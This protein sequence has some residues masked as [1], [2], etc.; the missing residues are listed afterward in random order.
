M[1][2]DF[3]KHL[4]TLSEQ[5]DIAGYVATEA[6]EYVVPEKFFIDLASHGCV[7]GMVGALI[8]Y[9]DTHVFFEYNYA[10]IQELKDEWESDCGE[11]LRIEDD[12]KNFL[13]WFAFEVKAYRMVNEWEGR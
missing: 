3:Q 2:T 11:T 5:N 13:S 8:R 4:E 7:S 1:K 9:K 6:L 12:I 10:E